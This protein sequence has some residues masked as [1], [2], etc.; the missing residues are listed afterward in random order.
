MS[1]RALDGLHAGARRFAPAFAALGD[2]TRL[3]LLAR[4][5]EEPRLSITQLTAGSRLTRQAITKH[6]RVLERAGMVLTLK[7]GRETRFEL[8]PKA[9]AETTAFLSA[10]SERWDRSLARLKAFAESTP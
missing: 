3:S 10:A 7:T 2:V 9:I 4:L 5:G 6:L 8:Q 1:S